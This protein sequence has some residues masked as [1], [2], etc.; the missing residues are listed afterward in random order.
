MNEYD[1]AATRGYTVVT[2][3]GQQDVSKSAAA[4]LATISELAV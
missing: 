4:V 3:A 2:V 1:T